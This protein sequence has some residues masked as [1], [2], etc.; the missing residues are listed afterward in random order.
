MP[1]REHRDRNNFPMLSGLGNGPSL[2]PNGRPARSTALIVS[3]HKHA[4]RS[5]PVLGRGMSTMSPRMWWCLSAQQSAFPNP[6]LRPIKQQANKTGQQF[7]RISWHSLSSN[8][9]LS[10][11]LW[12]NL[13]KSPP[14]RGIEHNSSSCAHRNADRITLTRLEI[15]ESVIRFL[16]DRSHFRKSGGDNSSGSRCPKC[17]Q[18]S[19]QMISYCLTVLLRSPTGRRLFSQV[20][21]TCCTFM[22]RM[23][24]AGNS[25]SRN[26]LVAV[27]ARNPRIF[28]CHPSIGV[29][30]LGHHYILCP[31]V[32]ARSP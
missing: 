7:R 26:F 12:R 14:I 10:G 8:V 3:G 15:V 18:K 20:S 31:R 25:K 13:R 2:P 16:M 11:G 23:M 32:W 21:S 28:A 9:S 29:R 6:A 17:R 27:L 19:R 24:N 22:V 30:L 1:S 5:T 4:R